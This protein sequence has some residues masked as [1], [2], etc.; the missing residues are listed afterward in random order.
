MGTCSNLVH[1][2]KWR[3]VLRVARKPRVFIGSIG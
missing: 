3:E 2:R 1:V